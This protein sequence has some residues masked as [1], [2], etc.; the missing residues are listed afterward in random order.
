[1]KTFWAQSRNW[2]FFK[3][4]KTSSQAQK[5]SVADPERFAADPDPAFQADADPDPKFV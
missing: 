5:S 1:M 2:K 4:L 3:S